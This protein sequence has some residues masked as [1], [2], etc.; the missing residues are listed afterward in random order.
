MKKVLTVLFMLACAGSVYAQ[1]VVPAAPDSSREKTNPA[2]DTQ[3]HVTDL[4]PD[5][6]TTPEIH[7]PPVRDYARIYEGAFSTAV[8]SSYYLYRTDEVMPGLMFSQRLDAGLSLPVNEALSINA[9]VY[10][11]KYLFNFGPGP[12]YT[13]GVHL[14]ADYRLA[15]WLTVGAYGQY[16]AGQKSML[17]PPFV[18]QSV[19]GVTGTAMFNRT[20]GVTGAVGKAFDPWTGRWR[21][22]YG[23][24]PVINL[25]SLFK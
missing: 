20:F 12:Q 4:K 14:Q 21:P 1:E 3:L 7:F 6:R 17:P 15:P 8:N 23:I 16:V 2:G 24:A 18:P 9:G 13:G 11:M 5:S 10:A 22:V 25:N 19:V